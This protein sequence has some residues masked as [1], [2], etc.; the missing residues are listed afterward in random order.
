M[1]VQTVAHLPFLL[2]AI[3]SVSATWAA[4]PAARTWPAETWEE[5]MPA[6]VGLDGGRLEKARRYAL[7][8]GGSG[9]I[10]R[11][12]K[13]VLMWGDQSTL[14]D[15]KSTTKSIGVTALGLAIADGKLA[16]T[17]RAVDR[18]PAFGIPPEAN[19]NRGW[20]EATTLQHL[21]TQTAGFEKTGGYG[22]LLFEPGTKWLY[23]DGGPNWLAECVTL[24]YGQDLQELIFERVFTPL[25][26]RRQDLRWRKNAYRPHTLGTLARRE[27]GSGI[28]ANVNAMARIGL[29]YLRGGTWRE[30]Q[31]VP[32]DFIDTARRP[33]SS[34][35]NLPAL[36]ADK[37]GNAS[38]HYGLL[39][40]N[41]A[42]GTL[43]GV[44]R[45]AYWSWGLHESLI[46]VI[47]SLDIVAV[48]AGRSWQRDW[49]DHYDVLAP[50]FGPIA[51]SVRTAAPRSAAPYPPSR[52][53]V[54]VSWAP[55]NEIVRK[56]KGSDNWPLTWGD[57]DA[58]YT[59]YGDGWG[60]E[61]KTPE[62]L[63]LGLARVTGN[64]PGFDGANV[65]SP[66]AEQTGDGR[67]GGKASGILMVEGVLYLWVRNTANSRLAWS[68]DRGKTWEWADW[69]FTES[70]G[71]PTFL[72]VG[73]DYRGARDG[74]V[75]VYS[76]DSD[77]AYAPSDHMVLARIPTSRVR[78]RSAYEFFAGL[79]AE[80]EP[81]WSPVLADRA[82]VFTHPGRCYRSAITYSVGLKRYLW[83]QIIPGKD[84]R[85]QGG[86]GIYDA[87]E[88]WGPWTTVFL[89]QQWDVGPG[90]TCSLPTK[91]M[92]PDGRT[93]HLVFS[94]DDH[95]SVREV[96]FIT[97]ASP[98]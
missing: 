98:K 30:Q 76:F 67:K 47:P 14:Y 15:L 87:P 54:G 19:G 91:W 97:P 2:P 22:K 43:S 55:R 93:A 9:I 11:G 38:A 58:L 95:F 39:W 45:D 64:P 27:F 63:S 51:A 6:A 83:C 65:R 32:T 23:S 16:L 53:I 52:A 60:F 66:S 31:L 20:L 69:R 72:N 80:G 57:D 50:F 29:L 79:G 90:E 74:F 17:D 10:T 85:F 25:G 18:H 35:A 48:R 12:G 44:P 3:A 21:A 28:H 34:V 62:K 75:Y 56:A 89:T 13:S 61:P 81:R 77:S 36:D 42:D 33:L 4:A 96:R 82:P 68:Q 8:G 88:P 7:T 78:D 26:I 41:N 94:G 59:A 71:C 70:F 86:F 84:T 92:S 5:A 49:D 40:W 24:A 1:H 46:L 73:P 37:H